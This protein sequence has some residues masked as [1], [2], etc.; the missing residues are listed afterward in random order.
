MSTGPSTL[1]ID[2]MVVVGVF[3]KDKREEKVEEENKNEKRRMKK[4]IRLHSTSKPEGPKHSGDKS[5]GS[6]Y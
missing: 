3:G 1:T 2:E 5:S 4:S 6:S